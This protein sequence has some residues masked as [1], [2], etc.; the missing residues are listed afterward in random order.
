MKKGKF[1]EFKSIN[2]ILSSTVLTLEQKQLLIEKTFTFFNEKEEEKNSEVYYSQYK[3]LIKTLLNKNKFIIKF[4][5]ISKKTILNKQHKI[6]KYIL[7]VHKG[8]EFLNLDFSNLIINLFLNLYIFILYKRISKEI[9]LRIEILK[10]IFQFYFD[11]KIDSL[12]SIVFSKWQK[13]IKFIFDLL[14]KINLINYTFLLSSLKHQK[15]IH[16]F[17][18]KNFYK[19]DIFDLFLFYV[20]LPMIV[21]P[22]PWIEKEPGLYISGGYLTNKESKNPKQLLIHSLKDGSNKL[23][24]SKQALNSINLL[25]SKSH[26][27]NKTSIYI[28]KKFKQVI[29][30]KIGILSVKQLK[31]L[32][33]KQLNLQKSLKI[34]DWKEYHKIKLKNPNFSKK[35]ILLKLGFTLDKDI[36]NYHLN[37]SLIKK[38]ESITSKNLMFKHCEFLINQYKDFKLYFPNFYD[39]RGRN[40]PHGWLLNRTSGFY[41]YLL[42][43][44]NYKR[45]SE[46]AIEWM[47]LYLK[48]KN[49]LWEWGKWKKDKN[50]FLKFTFWKKLLN[51]IAKNRLVVDLEVSDFFLSLIIIKELENHFFDINYRSNFLLEIDQS[52]SGPGIFSL[53]TRDS[54]IAFYSNILSKSKKQDL[55]LEFLKFLSINLKFDNIYNQYLKILNIDSFSRGLCKKII[56]FW[57]YGLTISGLKNLL[58]KEVKEASQFFSNSKL[59]YLANKIIYILQVFNPKINIFMTLL[60]QI[61]FILNKYNIPI[62]LF[63]L[64]GCYI[65]WRYFNKENQTSPQK[66]INFNNK[67]SSIRVVKEFSK[68]IKWDKN[69]GAFPP[70]F[71]HSI[72]GCL[73]RQIVWR[74]YKETE[75]ILI[76]IH[77]AFLVAPNDIDL[78][79]K[80]IKNIYFETFQSPEIFLDAILF[81]PFLTDSKWLV[82]NQI[83]V[84]FTKEL[85]NLRAQMFRLIQNNDFELSEIFDSEF[86]FFV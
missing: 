51:K 80:I 46:R 7:S 52:N 34:I 42:G 73:I 63:T 83:P 81:Q 4:I 75:E 40:Y 74:Y 21:K 85:F 37:L 50:L 57:F 23:C 31:E 53:I 64:D 58:E 14:E 48:E 2:S 60:K 15:T 28:F 6:N 54:T 45:L 56:M 18:N 9:S 59:Y 35:E 22:L 77:D 84:N 41:K 68:S 30:N 55:Y 69:V 39:F 72:D 82:K 49:P 12:S 17:L 43:N 20:N 61:I 1:I 36:F 5:S 32:K 19:N 26:F 11:I 13:I 3:D 70:N 71:I 27:F 65:K 16:I 24:L 78:L 44:T 66:Y 10:F 47:I 62:K 86:M 25:Q 29:K 8:P 76:P 33:W 67:L 38:I 79:Q